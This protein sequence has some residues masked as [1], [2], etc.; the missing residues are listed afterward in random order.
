MTGL[1]SIT[2]RGDGDLLVSDA[3]LGAPLRCVAART[4]STSPRSAASLASSPWRNA[5]KVDV[6][7]RSAGL[8]QE[9]AGLGNTGLIGGGQGST[10]GDVSLQDHAP[11]VDAVTPM[12]V[13]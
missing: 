8:A 3:R 7:G 2:T 11:L 5:A 10:P 1:A 12:R 6:E 4:S 13:A 9:G